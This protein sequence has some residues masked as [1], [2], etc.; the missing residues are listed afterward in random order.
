MG[1][2]NKT[3]GF[4]G[5]VVL[6]SDRALDDDLEHPEEVFVIID[7]L[8]VPFPVTEFDLLTDTSAR[9]QLEFV[10][11]QD[12]ARELVGCEVF[13]AISFREQEPETEPSWTGYAVHDTRHGKIG[14]VQNMEDYKGNVVMQIMDGKK[15]IL[16]SLYPEMIIR[17]DHRAKKIQITAPDGYF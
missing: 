14:V 17:I 6:V 12:E 2:I 3:H 15:E 16:I 10:D 13:T 4:N 5:T 8:P 7:G 1:K 9:L 11:N